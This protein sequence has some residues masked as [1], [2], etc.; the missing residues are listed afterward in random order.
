MAALSS[1]PHLRRITVDSPAGPM[2]FPAPAPIFVGAERRYGAV[3][4]VGEHRPLGAEAPS[5][6]EEL[7]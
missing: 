4:A 3:P 1:H 7:S 5:R 2:A 6:E